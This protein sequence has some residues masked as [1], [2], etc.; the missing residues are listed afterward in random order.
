MSLRALVDPSQAAL[1]LPWLAELRDGRLAGLDLRMPLALVPARGYI[2][3]FLTPPPRTPLADFEEEVA[4]VRATPAERVRA[5]TA[6]RVRRRRSPGPLAP[7]IEQPRRAVR[8]LADTLEEYWRRGL[9]HHWPRVRALL[10]ADLA[11]RA[12]HLTD[13]GPAM[14]F[15][16]L[17][18]S[19]AWRESALEVRQEY[20]ANV[21]LRGQGLL[22]VPSAFGWERPATITDPPWQ[23]TLVYPARGVAMLWEPGRRAPDGLARLVG[24]TRAAVLAALDAPRATTELA[25]RLGLS[26]GGA[27]QHLS[28][29]RG[30]GLVTSR[31][32]GRHVLYA[33]TPLADALVGEH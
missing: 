12:R 20:S 24:P 14:L 22:L 13:G 19:V 25:E 3:D 1:H 10:E 11:H 26:P 29:L 16:D 15:G 28:T 8:Q 21:D 2:P 9:A 23:P 27:S 33:R 18:H 30:A 31:R 32:A 5:E 4:R 6:H 7:L 17:H